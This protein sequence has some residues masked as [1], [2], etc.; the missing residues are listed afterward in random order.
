MHGC[1]CVGVKWKCY[2]RA[3]ST[4][5]DGPRAEK[6]PVTRNHSGNYMYV[7]RPDGLPGLALA[8]ALALD[9]FTMQ[10][11]YIRASYV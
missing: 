4:I 5:L 3:G 8:L 11:G 1:V 9:L 7:R 6:P 2:I 10:S